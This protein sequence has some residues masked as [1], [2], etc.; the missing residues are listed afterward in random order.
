MKAAGVPT[1]LAAQRFAGLSASLRKQTDI[2]RTELTTGRIA[3]LPLALGA[4]IGE[5]FSV[6]GALD[7]V[8][9]QKQGLSQAA[10]IATT[11]QRVLGVIG[12]GAAALA[13]DA[14]GAS[15]RRDEVAL[16]AAAVQAQARVRDAVIQLNTNVAGQSLFAGDAA[17]RAALASADQLL[18]DVSAIYAAASGPAALEAELDAYFN[19]PAGPFQSSIYTGG[20][21]P[22][23]TIEIARGERLQFTLRA[24]DPSIKDLLRGLSLIAAA[25]AA[26]PSTLRDS[27]LS[28]GAAAALA[29]DDALTLRRTEIG[30]AEQ[31]AGEAARLLEEEE[32]VLTEAFN[33]LTSR[34]PFEAASRLQSLEAQLNASLVITARLSQLTL[35]NFLR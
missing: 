22:A 11:A 3:D 24:D 31:R 33:A 30:V 6:R 8:A 4:Q 29:G 17:D 27:A 20:A 9:F 1:L 18:A 26:P 15:G 13:A 28:S 16:T 25:G 12:E 35:A 23:P 21:G 19:D 34:D 10:L 14:L 2:A 5:A 32:A 7:A